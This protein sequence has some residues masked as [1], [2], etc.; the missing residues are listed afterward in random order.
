ML[1]PI[2][3]PQPPTPDPR[4]P[5]HDHAEVAVKRLLDA[6]VGGLLAVAVVLVLMQVGSRLVGRPLAWT[7]EATRY[8]LVWV[9][10]L[11]GARVWL[12]RAHLAIGWRPLVRAPLVEAVV[13]TFAAVVLV[14]GGAR[15]VWLT[16]ELHQRSAALGLPLAL[17]YAVLPLAGLVVVLDVG[18]T[19]VRSRR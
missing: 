15:L 8:A 12:D 2:R 18:A 5:S 7:E 19:W 16:T 6:V 14:G 13:G 3:E 1:Q 17:V 11:G 4:E 9:G 10:M